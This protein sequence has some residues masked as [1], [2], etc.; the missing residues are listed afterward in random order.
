MY[1][2]E[3]S[4]MKPIKTFFKRQRRRMEDWGIQ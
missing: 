4:I 3:D 1:M 2:D